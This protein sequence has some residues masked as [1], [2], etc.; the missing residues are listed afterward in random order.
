[1]EFIPK[2]IAGKHGQIEVEYPHPD[3]KSILADTYGIIVYQEQIMQIASLMAGFSLGEADLLRRAVSKKKRETLDKERSHFVQGSLQ[4]GYNEKDANAVYDMI[5]RF[6]DYGFPRAHA[7]AY[8]VLAFQT[9]YLKAHY[10]VQFMASMLTAVMGTHR[11]VAE[12]VL[13]CRRTG[14]GVLPPDVNESGVLFTPVPG[15]ETGTGHIRFG[16][17]AIKNVGTLAVENIMLVRK[18]RPFDSLLDFCRRVDLRV[19]NK[20]VVESLLQAGAFDCLPGHR[21]QL[22]CWTR[23]LTPRRNGVRSGMNFKSS[24]STIWW[25]RRIGRFGIRIFLSSQ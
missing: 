4:Q 24:C 16:L 17:A 11:K 7:A 13:D 10:P 12:Y 25:R 22:L 20:R 8:G 21:A 5:V 3:L 14:I 19:C 18:E 9:A 6:A 2:Y 23:P 15:E 1:M